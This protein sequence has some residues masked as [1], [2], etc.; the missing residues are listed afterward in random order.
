MKFGVFLPTQIS[1]DPAAPSKV[2]EYA[3]RAED[4]GFD[5]LWVT[6]HVLQASRFYS[7]A[8]L[9]PIVTLAFAAAATS[10]IRLGTSVLLLPLRH[11]VILAKQIAALQ[12]LSGGRYIFGA[13]VGW[14]EPEYRAL[15]IAKSERGRRTDEVLAIMKSLL[16]E[17]GVNYEGEFYSLEDITIEPQAPTPPP[18]WIAGGSQLAHALSP[19]KGDFNPRVLDRVVASDGWIS[20]VTCPPELI[21]ADAELIRSRLGPDRADFVFAHENFISIDEVQGSRVREVQEPKYRSVLSDER[22]WSYIEAVYLTGGID[23]ALGKI[24]ARRRAGIEYMSFHTLDTGTDQL[25]L[26]AKHVIGSFA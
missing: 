9:E 2:A 8:W 26:I 17:R 14:F 22:P 25:E 24:E 1:N 7:V 3:K 12:Y 13:G 11:P 6:D 21:A 20:R 16:K 5:S 15:G 4:L 18:V 23:E 10:R 19:E